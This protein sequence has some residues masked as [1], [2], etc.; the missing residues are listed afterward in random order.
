MYDATFYS[1][2]T[3][4]KLAEHRS[5]LY[6]QVELLRINTLSEIKSGMLFKYCSDFKLITFVKYL[7]SVWQSLMPG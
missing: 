5:I 7:T 1:C 4:F 6:I 3:E 2:D